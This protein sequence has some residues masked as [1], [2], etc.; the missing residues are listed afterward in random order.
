LLLGPNQDLDDFE[1]IN[2]HGF[3]DLQE[4]NIP[5]STV[6]HELEADDIKV[7]FHPS[8]AILDQLFHFDDYCGPESIPDLASPDDQASLLNIKPWHPF[9]TKL[10]FEVAEVMLDAHMNR[11]QMERML[12]LIHEAARHPETFT[13]VN[14]N[15]LSNIW[16][17][18]RETRTDMVSSSFV[19]Q[20]LTNLDF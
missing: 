1:G 6:V 8:T 10:D 12:S 18:A 11:K 7:V 13:L 2:N 9:R 4:R 19:F 15:D 20:L 17:I 5:L 14:L 16:D 3:Q